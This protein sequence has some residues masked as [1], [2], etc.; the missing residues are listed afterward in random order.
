MSLSEQ[1]VQRLGQLLAKDLGHVKPQRV[2]RPRLRLVTPPTPVI[3]GVTRDWTKERIRFIRDRYRLHWLVTQ[4]LGSA[5]TMELM[6]DDA[7]LALGKKMEKAL[8]C[9]LDGINFED[10]GLVRGFD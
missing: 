4:E 5:P 6:E 10:A 8:G 3:D 1:E 2:E 9:I 7:L